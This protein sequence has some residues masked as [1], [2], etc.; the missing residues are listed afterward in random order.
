MRPLAERIAE[1]GA[2]T[3]KLRQ[4]ASEDPGQQI[5]TAYWDRVRA[6]Q[7]RDTKGQELTLAEYRDARWFADMWRAHC[8]PGLHLREV[9]YT[10]FSKQVRF[11]PG[12]RAHDK[13]G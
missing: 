9:F 7:A 10:L 5:E 6:L 13:R 12:L 2:E 8:R 3:E 11:A 4:R 1:R